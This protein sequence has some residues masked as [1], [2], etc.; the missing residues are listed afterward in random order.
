MT[1]K[2]LS[3][4]EYLDYSSCAVFTVMIV[5]GGLVNSVLPRS[6]SYDFYNY[7]ANVVVG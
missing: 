4:S 7:N 1:I 2:N 3:F 6:H 5:G